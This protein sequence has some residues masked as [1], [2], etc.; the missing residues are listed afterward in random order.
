MSCFVF[1]LYFRK[2]KLLSKVFSLL[3]FILGISC[4]IYFERGINNLIDG[5][6][7]N[8]PIIILLTL[9]PLISIPFKMNGYIKSLKAFFTLNRSTPFK[10][11]FK[12][13]SSIFFVG[14]VLN[15]GAI[16]VID[17]TVSKI[18][19]SSDLVSNAYLRGFSTVVLWSPYFSSVAL[20][21]YYLDLAIINYIKIAFPFAVVQL[22]IGYFIFRI[23][24]RAISIDSLEENEPKF[25]NHHLFPLIKMI[26][27]ICTLMLLVLIIEFLTTLP[28][29]LIVAV[30]ASTSSILLAAVQRKARKFKR[31][32]QIYHSR[33]I[34]KMNNEIIIFISAGIFSTS[35]V[36]T[37]VFNFMTD[38]LVSISNVS[39]TLLLFMIIFSVI[40][41]SIVGF[42][43]A[44]FV[45]PFLI[46]ISP[47]DL[48]LSSEYLA[49]T[50]MVSWSFSTVLSPTNP[51]NLIVSE[52]VNRS[53]FYVGIKNNWLFTLIMIVLSVLYILLLSKF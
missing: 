40:T 2:A 38:F 46:Q 45:I 18:H 49:F 53:S 44:I 5:I 31:Y 21:L 7:L 24:K 29:L 32:V 37:P 16:R 3:L 42:H 22:L 20:V 13:S 52:A 36:N 12:I 26:G 50:M 14:P 4:N 41:F 51:L 33:N 47:Q 23:S 28:V 27:V 6:I 1:L 39:T 10:Q 43:P 8:I 17:E 48:G 19:L 25:E 9:V 35:I 34:F 11:Y 15:L 30:V